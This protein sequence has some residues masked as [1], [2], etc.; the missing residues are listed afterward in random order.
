M[1]PAMGM[2]MGLG[3]GLGLRVWMAERRVEAGPSVW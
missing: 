3:M 2:G 1:L